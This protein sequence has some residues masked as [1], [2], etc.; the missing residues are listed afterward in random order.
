M[1]PWAEGNVV[2]ARQRFTPPPATHTAQLLRLRA[3]RLERAHAASEAARRAHGDA[4]EQVMQR[5]QSIARARHALS[6]LAQAVV[7]HL[8]GTLPRWSETVQADRDR[9]DERLEREEYALID[10]EQ[11]LEAALEAWQAARAEVARLTARHG[12]IDDLHRQALRHRALDRERRAERLA[13]DRPVGA[14]R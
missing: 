3:L 9:L 2:T 6:T 11:A 7:G 1:A 5:Q 14:P 4:A 10:D 8:A 13:G 12:A